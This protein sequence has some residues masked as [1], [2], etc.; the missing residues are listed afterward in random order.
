VN[1]T[2]DGKEDGLQWGVKT[3]WVGMG[4]LRGWRKGKRME[5]EGMED[6]ARV[7]NRHS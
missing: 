5:E 7:K 6:G 3:G 4:R 1:G 2:C